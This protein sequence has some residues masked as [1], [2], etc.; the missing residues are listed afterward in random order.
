MTVW[1]LFCDMTFDLFPPSVQVI[2][3]D[4]VRVQNKR[5]FPADLLLLSSRYCLPI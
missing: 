4:I 5:F 3:G 2:V 1:Q